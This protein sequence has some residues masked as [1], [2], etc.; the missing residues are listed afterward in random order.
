[1]PWLRGYASYIHMVHPEE[2]A[3]FLEIIQTL[4]LRADP[5]L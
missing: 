3:K 1:L 2:G 5:A 4:E